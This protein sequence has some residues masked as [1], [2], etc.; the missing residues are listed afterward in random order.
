MARARREREAGSGT[1]ERAWL[2]PGLYA[3]EE[4]P[5]VFWAWQYSLLFEELEARPEDPGWLDMVA[6]CE[7][8]GTF[9]VKQRYDQHF[10]TDRCRINYHGRKA[11]GQRVQSKRR[12][13]R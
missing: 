10:D 1:E 11:A 2:K 3:G 5:K 9:Y 6:T 7:E 12:R 8:C 13:N 4:S